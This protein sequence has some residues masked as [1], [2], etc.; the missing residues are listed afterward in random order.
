VSAENIALVKRIYDSG[1]WR[2]DGDPN[3]ALQWLA[4]DFAFVNP[5]HAVV[6]GVRRGHDGVLA[7][8]KSLDEGFDSWSNDPLAFEDGADTV[9]VGTRFV[10]V[11]AQS[12]IQ[13]EHEEW[14]VWKVQDGLAQS[15]SWFHD[16]D[17]A[18]A[19]AGI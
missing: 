9:L 8:R 17:A 15:L 7:A 5:P 11:G 19:A 13:F 10:C 3:A 18:R 14:H 12:G 2:S 4:E 1:A 16:P 6:P